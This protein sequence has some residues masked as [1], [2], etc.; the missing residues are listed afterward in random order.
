MKIQSHLSINQRK[1]IRRKLN[2]SSALHKT[3]I[4]LHRAYS[5]LT[6]FLHVMPNFFVLGVEKGGTSSL[7]SYL[8][9]HP[10]IFSAV[11]KEI[12]LKLLMN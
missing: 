7:Y 5:N 10:M 1:Q 2:S 3:A 12:N 11:T 6:G 8:V 9:R 4:S